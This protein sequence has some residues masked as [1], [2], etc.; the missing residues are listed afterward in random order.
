MK[1][2]MKVVILVL[3]A[4]EEFYV[5]D[6]EEGIDIYPVYNEEQ[7]NFWNNYFDLRL[8]YLQL[9]RKLTAKDI[10]LANCG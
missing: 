9:L 8:D 4:I 6:V 2:G 5:E 7:K 3:S 1:N 10:V